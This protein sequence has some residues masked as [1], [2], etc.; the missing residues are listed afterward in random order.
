MPDPKM[1]Y[2]PRNGKENVFVL[3]GGSGGMHSRKIFTIKGTRLAK[4]AFPEISAL[5]N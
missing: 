4:N 1:F 3:L 5:K 2:M